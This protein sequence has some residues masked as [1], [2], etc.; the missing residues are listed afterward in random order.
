MKAIVDFLKE[1]GR[2]DWYHDAP[3]Q[4]RMYNDITI[5]ESEQ[6][7]YKKIAPMYTAAVCALVSVPTDKYEILQGLLNEI[8]DNQKNFE[9]PSNELLDSLMRDYEHSNY[10]V[11]G[12]KDDYD[13]LCFVRDCMR[14]QMYY[15]DNFKKKIPFQITQKLEVAENK[16]AVATNPVK[17]NETIKGVKGLAVYLKI[18]VTK[19]QDIINSQVL[20]ENGVAYRVGNAWNF[21]LQKLEELLSKQPTILYKR[22]K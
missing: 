22:N 20:Q 4:Q 19:A 17:Q 2:S 9:M 6:S 10:Q 15:L 8:E 12:L 18:G 1:M 21:N 3:F 16:D 11:H 13:Y 14:V 5:Q 7:Y